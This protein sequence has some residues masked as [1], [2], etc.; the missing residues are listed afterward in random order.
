M[1]DAPRYRGRLSHRLR[2][3]RPSRHAPPGFTLIELLVVITVISLLIAILLPALTAARQA[4]QAITCGST[5]RQILIMMHNYAVDSDGYWPLATRTNPNSDWRVSLADLGMVNRSQNLSTTPHHPSESHLARHYC[6][7][8]IR[9]NS[10]AMPWRAGSEPGK[11]IG[12]YRPAANDYRHA[13][14]DEV[15]W[16][17]A[18][19]ALSESAHG[20]VSFTNFQWETSVDQALH[21]SAANYGMI[22]G[23]VG[24]HK[25]GWLT[26]ARYQILVQP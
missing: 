16:P 2:H 25:D 3:R 21:Q 7:T 1:H 20:G 4:A 9:S 24:R 13:K 17:S 15:R 19:I 11:S 5:T 6:P 26:R 18:K 12:G 14:D 8:S 10:Y 22:D 23:H